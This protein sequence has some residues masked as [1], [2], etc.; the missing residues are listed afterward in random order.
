MVLICWLDPVPLD[1]VQSNSVAL[2][3]SCKSMVYRS[4]LILYDNTRMTSLYFVKKSFYWKDKCL[5][6]FRIQLSFV[7]LF[8]I[9]FWF[10]DY[11]FWYE[12]TSVG[13]P[14]H[15]NGHKQL[16]S[17]D[18]WQTEYY[19]RFMELCGKYINVYKLYS[20]LIP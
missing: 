13:L 14:W 17:P 3:G 6:P 19:G 11:R 12:Y 15:N 1:T 2:E 4:V 7:Y 16:Y 8:L 5:R 20:E 18:S 9:Y 10:C